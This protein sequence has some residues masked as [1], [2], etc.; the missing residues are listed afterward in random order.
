MYFSQRHDIDDFLFNS[1][2]PTVTRP[3]H[4]YD[5]LSSS[6]PSAMTSTCDEDTRRR[7]A[8]TISVPSPWSRRENG[9]V[10]RA[11]VAAGNGASSSKSSCS[12]LRVHTGFSLVPPWCTACSWELTAGT[13]RS[14][15]G[16]TE[17]PH[18]CT[19]VIRSPIAEV[20]RSGNRTPTA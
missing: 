16:D 12:P 14:T 6:E 3:A 13:L 20:T 17:E 10:G 8:M 9:R 11:L 19:A 4:G 7:Q 2:D 5:D 1:L 18:R 15:A